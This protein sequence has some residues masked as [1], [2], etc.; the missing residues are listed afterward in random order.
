MFGNCLSAHLIGLDERPRF[1]QDRLMKV[2]ALLLSASLAG[3]LSVP[4]VNAADQPVDVAL[5][6]QYPI[7]Y[8][9]IV[10]KWLETKLLDPASAEIEWEGDPKPADLGTKGQHLYGY[11]VKFKVN[12][13]NRFGAYTGKQEHGA[14]IR[15]GEVIKGVGFGY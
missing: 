5:Y 2:M 1:G 3:I 12:S 4:N 6:G 15:N 7:G 8:K 14:L 9:E 10:T 11:L 13:R